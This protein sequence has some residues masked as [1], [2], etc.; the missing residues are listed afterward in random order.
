MEVESARRPWS[1]PSKGREGYET[2]FHKPTFITFAGVR[3]TVSTDGQS[4]DV[5]TVQDFPFFSL[6]NASFL[7]EL[8]TA[9]IREFKKCIVKYIK[10][11]CQSSLLWLRRKCNYFYANQIREF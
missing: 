2:A 4:Y 8:Q 1:I 10:I 9:T 11:Q 6:L 5:T 3:S 7:R